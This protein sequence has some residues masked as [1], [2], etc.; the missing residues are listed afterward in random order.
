MGIAT[1]IAAIS[2]LGALAGG[3]SG[4]TK[5]SGGQAPVITPPAVPAGPAPD[6]APEAIQKPSTNLTAPA[7]A[8]LDP[9]MT[10]LQ[11]RSKIA[12]LGT[13]GDGKFKDSAVVDYWKNILQQD[14][15]G[16]GFE[17]L[18]Q[19]YQYAESLGYKPRERTGTSLISSILRG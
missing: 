10:N 12:T 18:P 7:W 16:D 11:K 3:I 1:A 2:A 6:L 8:G 13:Q 9:G 17:P 19:E 4:M 15:T 14:Y 5:K